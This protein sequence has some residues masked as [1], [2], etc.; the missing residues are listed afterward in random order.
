[1]LGWLF[2]ALFDTL[3]RMYQ[4]LWNYP[5]SLYPELH[6]CP[7]LKSPN[8]HQ[9]EMCTE[10]FIIFTKC[11]CRMTRVTTCEHNHHKEEHAWHHLES[12][13]D[14]RACPDLKQ[15]D[16]VDEGCCEMGPGGT[17][18]WVENRTMYK[19]REPGDGKG[20]WDGDD[21]EMPRMSRR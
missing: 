1:V 19:V 21:F 2:T 9:P 13:P 17:C 3:Q 18:L 6:P 11:P 10:T 20:R 14:Y 12:V 8:L 5:N 4:K 15:E 16:E 7:L